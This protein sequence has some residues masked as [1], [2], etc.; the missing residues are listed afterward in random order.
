MK[1]KLKWVNAARRELGYPVWTMAQLLEHQ[2]RK[3][4]ENKK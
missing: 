4:N 1:K 3:I 2:K